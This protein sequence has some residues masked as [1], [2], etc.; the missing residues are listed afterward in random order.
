MVKCTPLVI[1]NPPTCWSERARVFP[2]GEKTLGAEFH[3]VRSCNG[4]PSSLR[5][6]APRGGGGR[7]TKRAGKGARQSRSRAAD[8]TWSNVTGCGAAG[9]HTGRPDSLS[10]L[11]VGGSED[12]E[13]IDCCPQQRNQSEVE[14]GRSGCVFCQSKLSRLSNNYLEMMH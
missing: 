14:V 8:A 2:R 6:S 5:V 1:E 4:P 12:K 3:S 10:F 9:R 13:D 11:W 7:G